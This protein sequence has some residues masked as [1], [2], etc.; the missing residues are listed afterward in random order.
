MAKKTKT[1]VTKA[2]AKKPVSKAAKKP[3]KKVV[4]KKA[5]PKVQKT[6]PQ[7]KSQKIKKVKTNT[8]KSTV[9]V[10]KAEAITNWQSYLAPLYDKVLLQKEKQEV[11]SKGGLYLGEADASSSYA[12]AK[13][14]AVGKGLLSKKG[15]VRPLD[16]SE[17][18]IV[19]YSSYAGSSIK[20]DGQ[21]LV[22]V[23]EEEILGIMEK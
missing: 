20:V 8:A 22:I 4:A 18:D 11:I 10:S 16:V 1:K 7:K 13:V 19:M 9:V 23:K 3:V 21:E 5:A 12:K 14:L 6:K 17:G 15:Q 2:K